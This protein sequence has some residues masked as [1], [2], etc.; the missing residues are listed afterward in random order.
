[1]GSKRWKTLRHPGLGPRGAAPPVPHHQ[2]Q[3]PP[4]VGVDLF[5]DP[6]PVP[7]SRAERRRLAKEQRR[8]A[9]RC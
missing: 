8:E 6:D 4:A 9:A 2:R 7:R 1:M 3:R 5:A